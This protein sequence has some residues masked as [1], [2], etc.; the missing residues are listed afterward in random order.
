MSTTNKKNAYIGISSLA[1]YI[2]ILIA[3]QLLSG[4]RYKKNQDNC[5]KQKY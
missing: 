1:L 5:G 3:G 4:P 2:F